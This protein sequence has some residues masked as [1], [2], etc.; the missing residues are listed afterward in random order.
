MLENP[1]FTSVAAVMIVLMIFG[2]F[3]LIKMSKYNKKLEAENEAKRARKEQ[4]AQPG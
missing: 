1:G 3:A 4:S 2:V